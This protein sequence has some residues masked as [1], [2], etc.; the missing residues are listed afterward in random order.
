MHDR[1]RSLLD[2][3][4][5][6]FEPIHPD[7]Y[8]FVAGFVLLWLLLLWIAPPLGWV[9]IVLVLWC[10]YF[11]RDPDRVT[12]LREGLV[13]SPADGRISAI[14]T[15][16]PPADLDLGSEPRV[17]ISV[18]LTIFDVHITRTPVPGKI[19]RSVYIPGL[20]LNAE[21]DKASEDNER[22][23]LTIETSSGTRIGCVQ[24]AGL[25][26]RRIVSFVSEG[27]VVGPGERLG[28]IRFGSRADVYLPAGV[29]PLVAVGQRAIGGETVFADIQSQ[30]GP[31]QGRRG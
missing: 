24:I 18:F 25:V 22:Q 27:N 20:F 21:L 3:I 15:V 5:S 13:V 8:K 28:L 26:A 4:T 14:E 1:K 16:T 30:E 19:V 7:G 23:C 11:F 17:R 12:P 29:S 2:T 9:G 10:V 6:V 31:R